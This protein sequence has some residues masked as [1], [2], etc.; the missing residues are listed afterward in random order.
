MNSAAGIR[1]MNPP[2]PHGSLSC[3]LSGLFSSTLLSL[4]EP[5]RIY[6]CPSLPVGEEKEDQ[7]GEAEVLREAEVRAVD[8]RAR[9]KTKT[10]SMRR[11][12]L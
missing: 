7:E 12:L 2:S 8:G 5:C 10:I 9:I 1:K 4:A 3:A 6:S 11:N